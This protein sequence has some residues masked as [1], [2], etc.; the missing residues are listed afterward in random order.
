VVLLR[1]VVVQDVFIAWSIDTHAF[2]SMRQ[3][4][5]VYA[6]HVKHVCTT[7]VLDDQKHYTDII[8]TVA[9]YNIIMGNLKKTYKL[10]HYFKR[11]AFVSIV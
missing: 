9:I 6:G 4:C 11:E 5:T 3:G 2:V 10:H 8:K 1:N 7:P